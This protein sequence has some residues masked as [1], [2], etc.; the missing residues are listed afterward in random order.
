M[1]EVKRLWKSLARDVEDLMHSLDRTLLI[2]GEQVLRDE[3]A[4][5]LCK[6][7]DNMR[8]IHENAEGVK[9]ES[10]SKNKR[11]RGKTQPTR[12]ARARMDT[13]K[14]EAS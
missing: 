11:V 4:R 13:Q 2:D 3:E 8:E 10:G 9:K 14:N 6:D 12:S 7:R 1:E 5:I